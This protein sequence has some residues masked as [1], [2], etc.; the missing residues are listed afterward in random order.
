M[1]IKL[2]THSYCWKTTLHAKWYFDRL[3][4]V[5]WANSQFA[6]VRFLS[7]SFLSLLHTHRLHWWT[8]FDDL[9][10]IWRLSAQGFFFGG[11]IL[12]IYLPIQGVISP[13]NYNFG[14]HELAFSSQTCE[15]FKLSY[16]RHCCMDSNQILHPNKDHEVGFLGGPETWQTNPIWQTAAIL[17][18]EKESWYLR[19]HLTDFDEIWCG[20]AIVD[21]SV[22]HSIL[23]LRGGMTGQSAPAVLACWSLWTTERETGYY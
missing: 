3:T 16:Y 18:N 10:V 21:V 11:G 8:D 6:P 4:W 2:E 7:L 13:Q 17:K 12:L 14:G 5:V 20:V 1:L 19:N 22:H 15:I 23:P 9:Y